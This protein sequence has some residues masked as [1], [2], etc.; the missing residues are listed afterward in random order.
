MLILSEN[1]PYNGKY[2]GVAL[3][4]MV[5]PCREW[6]SLVENGRLAENGPALQRMVQPYR[7]YASLTDN[8]PALQRMLSLTNNGPAL[9]KMV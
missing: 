6:S 9:H 2:N 7:D 1:G 5:K 4:R 3:N 8:S